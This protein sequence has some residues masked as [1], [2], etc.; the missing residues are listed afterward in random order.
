MA[1]QKYYTNFEDDVKLTKTA[2]RQSVMVYAEGGGIRC[3]NNMKCCAERRLLS[4]LEHE[5]KNAGQ[6]GTKKGK[7]IQKHTGGVIKIWRYTADGEYGKVFPCSICRKS[8]ANY[9]LKVQ[10]TM[11]PN[12]W[13]IGYMEEDNKIHSKPTT[14]QRLVFKGENKFPVN[15]RFHV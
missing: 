8:I 2:V 5:A 14:A 11:G 3:T 10:C 15:T 13:F 4:L 6:K 12:E 9:G 7:W 1:S